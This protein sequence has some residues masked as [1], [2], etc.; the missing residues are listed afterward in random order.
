[1]SEKKMVSRSVAVGLGTICTILI[2]GLGGAVA[3]YTSTTAPK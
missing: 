1:M 2:V 3:Y